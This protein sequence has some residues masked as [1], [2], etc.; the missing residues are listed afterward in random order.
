MVF[1]A[2]VCELL[3]CDLQY[4]RLLE[5]RKRAYQLHEPQVFLQSVRLHRH[6]RLHHCS[7]SFVPHIGLQK[8]D[9]G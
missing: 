4:P 3:R 8:L 7:H 6:T 5:R 2:C 1:V 9:V